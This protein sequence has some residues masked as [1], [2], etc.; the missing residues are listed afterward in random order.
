MPVLEVGT[1]VGYFK[2]AS[3]VACLLSGLGRQGEEESGS[4]AGSNDGAGR[5]VPA[6]EGRDGSSVFLAVG[7]ES[8]VDAFGIMPYTGTRSR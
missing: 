7:E 4:K 8:I 1:G 3:P 2:K 5:L 6:M